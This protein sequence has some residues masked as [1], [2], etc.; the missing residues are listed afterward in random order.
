MKILI[1]SQEYAPEEVSSA[2]V[3]RELAEDLVQRGHQVSVV[4]RA[5]NYPLGKVSPG[6]RNKLYQVE[7]LNGVRVHRVWSYITPNKGFWQRIL[8]FGTYSAAAFYGGL[9]AQKPDLVVCYSPPLPLGVSCWLL[10]RVWRI[11]WVLRVED[12]FPEAAVAAGVLTSQRAIQFFYRLASFLY[13]RSERISVITEGF[14]RRLLQKN[15]PDE[16]ITVNPCWADPDFV[17]PQPKENIFRQV[18][19]LSGKFV[20]MYAGALGLTSALEDVMEAAFILRGHSDIIFVIVGEGTK[21]LWIQQYIEQHSLV[22]AMVLPF[23]PRA[24]FPQMMA[25]ANVSLVTLNQAF[26]EFSLPHKIFDI[27]ASNRPILGVAPLEC[28]LA[29]LIQDNRCGQVVAPQKAQ[30]LAQTILEMKGDPDS[31]DEMG[32]HGRALLLSTY[33]RNICIDGYEKMFLKT[34]GNSPM[35]HG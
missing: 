10:S 4:T 11:P 22:N 16:K 5:P 2:I 31:L 3:V 30:D 8:S 19:G 33:A 35:G 24:D 7:Y 17:T 20:V 27:M 14:R 29:K 28:D 9:L 6:Y 12:L 26:S 18:H 21:K 15:V 25:A 23:Q 34:L 1:L 13:R 32:K